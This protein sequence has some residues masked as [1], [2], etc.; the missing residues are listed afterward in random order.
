MS[1]ILDSFGE[2]PADRLIGPIDRPQQIYRY[3]DIDGM[4]VR[5]IEIWR[6]S[7]WEVHYLPARTSLLA[8]S[9]SEALHFARLLALGQRWGAKEGDPRRK[10]LMIEEG[11]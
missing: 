11:P 4:E 8:Q 9:E 2:P 7:S 1:A 3:I 10:V 5:S 6:R